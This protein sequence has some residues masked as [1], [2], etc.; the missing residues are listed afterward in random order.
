MSEFFK[1]LCLTLILS[2]CLAVNADVKVTVTGQAAGSGKIVKQQALADA[3][4]KAVQKGAG[5]NIVSSTKAT[6]YV[7]DFDRVFSRAFGYVKTFEIL[8]SGYDKAG[9]F[10]VRIS[11]A[12]GKGNPDLDDYLSMRQIIAMKGSPRLLI[13]VAGE[14]TG[15][16]NAEKL[17]DGQLREIALKCGFQTV[18]LSQLNEAEAKRLKRDMLLEK[19]DSAAYRMSGV[20][21]NYDFVIDAGIFG[22]YNGESE[23]YGV[24]TQRFSLGADLGAVYPGGNAIAQVT[25]PGCEM[26]IA[27][28]TDKT[29]AARSALQ[30]I[31]SGDSGR[32]FRSLLMRILASWISEFDTGAKITVELPGVSHELF[33]EIVD[34]LREAKGVNAVYIR[35]FN[36][37][38][39]SI[40]EVESNLAAYDLGSLTSSLSG[41]RLAAAH[42]GS[43][44]VQMVET[45]N[46]SITD[47]IVLVAG[48][49]AGIILLI[50]IIGN[51]RARK[52]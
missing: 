17:I 19:G 46:L 16:G 32:N 27:Q 9:L 39:K 2:L 31:L 25:I 20:R 44:F 45:G 50:L 28:V 7:L 13:R 33:T 30:K 34:G 48:A 40:I 21:E 42:S 8:S 29:Q 23:L 14:I 6:D 41:G 12:V 37:Q 38:L 35:E 10:N 24:T 51:L 22:A 49:A 47:M 52:S 18:K 3:L 4:R 11:A 1:M 36:E 43:D 15:I 5:V 26:N